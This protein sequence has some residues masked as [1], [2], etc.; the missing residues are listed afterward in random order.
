MK[1]KSEEGRG[2]DT[3]NINQLKERMKVFKKRDNSRVNKSSQ[4]WFTF[5]R[6]LIIPILSRIY[7]KKG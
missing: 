3:K 5:F 2:K 6:L 4:K 1:L 7:R